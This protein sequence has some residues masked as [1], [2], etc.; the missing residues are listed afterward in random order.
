M[1]AIADVD[2]NAPESGLENRM[3]RVALEVVCGLVKVTNARNVVFTMFS[4]IRAV[5]INHNCM[6]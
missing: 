3:A 6:H 5:S 1:T 2:G 4:K